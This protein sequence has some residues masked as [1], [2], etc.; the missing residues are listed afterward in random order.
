MVCAFWVIC[1]IAQKFQALPTSRSPCSPNSPERSATTAL[2]YL[3]SRATRCSPT[4]ANVTGLGSFRDQGADQRRSCFRT[5][6]FKQAGLSKEEKRSPTS[7][8]T[9]LRKRASCFASHGSTFR[10]G[11]KQAP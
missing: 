7:A 8:T 1:S 11:R 5:E 4:N 6:Y 10:L 3:N 2:N 9:R